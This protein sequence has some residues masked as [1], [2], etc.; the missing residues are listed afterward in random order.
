MALI[1]CP[2]CHREISDRARAC[3]QCGFPIADQQLSKHVS[4]TLGTERFDAGL[5]EHLRGKTFVVILGGDWKNRRFGPVSWQ[6]DVLVIGGGHALHNYD[7]N[8]LFNLGA[9]QALHASGKGQHLE[10][11]TPENTFTFKPFKQ[12]KPDPAPDWQQTLSRLVG[13]PI[14]PERKKKSWFERL[15]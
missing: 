8:R 2:E 15:L 12:Q 7:H 13:K 1:A 6:E 3:P 10:I 11:V 9:I 4:T 14:G 5:K